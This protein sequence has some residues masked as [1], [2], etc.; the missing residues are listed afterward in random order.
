MIIED[1]REAELT[2]DHPK[3]HRHGRERRIKDAVAATGISWGGW[4]WSERS[5]FFAST[6]YSPERGPADQFWI[7]PSLRW[8]PRG[9]KLILV[10]SSEE[11]SSVR[12][13]LPGTMMSL[14]YRYAQ[15]LP[16]S[17]SFASHYVLLSSFFIQK[18]DSKFHHHQLPLPLSSR[19]KS[20]FGGWDAGADDTFNEMIITQAYWMRGSHFFFFALESSSD[21]KS[22]LSHHRHHCFDSAPHAANIK[23]I[24]SFPPPL[25]DS[26]LLIWSRS[27][28]SS[29]DDAIISWRK[30]NFQGENAPPRV[31]F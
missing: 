2:D 10:K 26:L 16:F 12:I 3:N 5:L 1:R 4:G 20:W 17:A 6:D 28:W 13:M 23:R 15:R 31:D 25:L 30:K 27:C 7:T 8:S 11:A 9:H 24:K 14:L 29:Y 19:C 21:R 18:S 22:S